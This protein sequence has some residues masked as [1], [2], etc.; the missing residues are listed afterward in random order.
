MAGWMS[1][2]LGKSPVLAEEIFGSTS[3]WLA[4]SEPIT[5]EFIDENAVREPRHIVYWYKV[6]NSGFDY[7]PYC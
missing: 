4:V 3:A 1:G 5:R 7:W 6:N 2:I